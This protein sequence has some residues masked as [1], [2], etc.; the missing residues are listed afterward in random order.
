VG[1]IAG[2]SE[3]RTRLSLVGGVSVTVCTAYYTLCLY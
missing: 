1:L 3:L 2:F